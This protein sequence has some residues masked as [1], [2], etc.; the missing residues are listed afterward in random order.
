MKFLVFQHVSHEHPG[1]LQ[2]C[3][4]KRGV[5]FDI[6][7][8]WKSYA[9]PDISGYDA[10]MIIGGPMG[11]YEDSAAFPSKDDEIAV[12]KQAIEQKIPVIGFCLGSQLIAHALG[13]RVYPNIRDGKK[14]KEIG[15][16]SVELTDDG[17][18]DPLFRE[19]VS[20][21]KVLQWH[22]DAFDLPAGAVLLA[23]SPV[24]AQ[25]FRHGTNVYGLL[26][27]NEFTPEMVNKQIETDRA[28]VHDGFDLDE[29]VLRQQAIE[30]APLMEQQC[31]MLFE[32]FLSV[33]KT[34]I[35]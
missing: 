4:D 34:K 17:K 15:Y 2:V 35:L 9:I 27:H 10:L 6:V 5:R 18:G 14:L 22:G 11:V 28:W 21:I 29:G 7:E 31:G 23:K 19:F 12:I 25:A 20:P 33:V 30:F 13:A 24:C 3:A 8:F 1:L 32:N 26:F 16:Y